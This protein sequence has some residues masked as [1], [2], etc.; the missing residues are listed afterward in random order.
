M[1]S[2]RNALLLGGAA[3]MAPF[4]AARGTESTAAESLSDYALNVGSWWEDTP[5]LERFDRAGE[6]GFSAVEMWAVRENGRTAQDIRERLDANGLE[7]VQI[8][9]WYGPGLTDVSQH[10]AF[11]EAMKRAVEDADTLG[12][13]MFTVVGHQDDPLL[14]MEE[15]LGR[16][17][18]AYE[19][20]LPLMEESGKIMLLEP[21]NEFDHPGH[22]IYGSPEAVELCRAVDSPHLK[23][24]WDLF[25]MQRHEGEIIQRFRDGIDQVAYVQLADNPGRHQPGTGEM[26]Y[27]NI[28]KEIRKAGYD[29]YFGLECWAR[30]KDYAQAV[31]DV[32]AVAP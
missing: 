17:R 6:A 26:N 4:A 30:D 12:A 25:H 3:A 11:R 15:K 27:A 10:E 9:A 16:L 7:M 23:L 5:F 28:F 32:R 18:D 24:N 8:L 2:R 29:G 21:F 14:S 20:A 13:R 19:S 1:I 31:E 22:F